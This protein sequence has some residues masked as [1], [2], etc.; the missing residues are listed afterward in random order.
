[1]DQFFK[2][3]NTLNIFNNFL[4]N[5][6]FKN[7]VNSDTIKPV[8]EINENKDSFNINALNKKK[9]RTNTLKIESGSNKGNNSE[10]TL[11]TN[12]A[13]K[14]SKNTNATGNLKLEDLSSFSFSSENTDKRAIFKAFKADE[15]CQYEMKKMM[16]LMKNR[17]S[18]RKCR[19]KKKNYLGELER[20]LVETTTELEKLKN[21]QKNEKNIENIICI[22]I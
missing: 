20:K 19:Q 3:E 4:E 22:V 8:S 11:N 21:I 16:R 17:L 15:D 9:K 13:R 10:T 1:M 2:S 18:A 12:Y 14:N 6:I 5:N 7:V